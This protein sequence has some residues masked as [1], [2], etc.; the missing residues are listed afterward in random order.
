[1]ALT[2][3]LGRSKPAV[4]NSDPVVKDTGLGVQR[5]FPTWGDFFVCPGDI[6]QCFGTLLETFLV[7][8]AGGGGGCYWHLMGTSQG[9]Y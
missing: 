1:M 4:T 6:W 5:R 2:S 7:I 9:C 3:S 8:I